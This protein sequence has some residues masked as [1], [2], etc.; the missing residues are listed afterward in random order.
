[1]VWNPEGI[2]ILGTP[3]GSRHFVRQKVTERVD[4][5]RRLWEAIP[6]VPDLQCEWQI[7]LQCAGPRCHHMLRTLPPT[8]SREYAEEHD[9]GMHRTM[10][11]RHASHDQTIDAGGKLATLPMRLGRLGLRSAQ[12]V[13]P[14][15]FWAS[16]ADALHMIH[17]RLP[18]VARTIT[19][20]LNNEVEGDGCL[21]E[22]KSAAALLDHHGFVGRP[23]WEQLQMGVRPPPANIVEPGEWPHGWQ[24]YASSAS[25]HF[26]R[27]TVVLSQTGAANQAHLRS[28]SGHGPSFALSGT[29]TKP[30]FRVEPHHFRTLVLERMKLP[31]HVAEAKC[32]C[33]AELDRLG[34]HRAACP[35]S[36]RLRT[37]ALGPERSLARI[38]RQAGATVRC[39]AKLRD[40]DIAVSAED[41]RAIEVLALGLPLHHVAQLAV[42]VTLRCAL[43]ANGEAHPNAAAEDGAICSRA[44]ADKE[45]K[46]AELLAGDRCRLVVVALETGG[47]WSNEAIQ[48]IDDL[49]AARAREAPPVMRR[50]AFLAWKRRWSRMI[51]ISCARAF[52]NSLAAVAT[53]PHTLAGVDGEMPDMADLLGEG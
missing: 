38:C 52:A 17:E 37:R 25:E 48:F 12:R 7:L 47:R 26:F 28:H 16:W 51:G 2:K 44:R 10:E 4:E 43:K 15:A 20:K 31:L 46:Y 9:A 49:A 14:G 30:E 36:G 53:A 39:N 19:H 27:R 41:E 21:G 35:M 40:M 32:E 22:L 33:G 11:V 29:P 3:V 18:A 5:E 1:M 34:R 8:Q 24:Y 13:A 23:E 45:R 50:S 6:H 42:D